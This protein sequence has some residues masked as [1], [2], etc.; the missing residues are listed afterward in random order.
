LWAF[1]S[2]ARIKAKRKTTPSQGYD[3]KPVSSGYAIYRTWFN[4]E[5]VGIDKDPLTSFL[6]KGEDVLYG[7]IGDYEYLAHLSP[8]IAPPLN[9]VLWGY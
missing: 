9:I 4:T 7:W 3:D 1:V 6:A 8:W 5:E 2:I